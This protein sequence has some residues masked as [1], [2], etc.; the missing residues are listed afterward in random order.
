MKDELFCVGQANTCG[1][2]DPKESVV[3]LYPELASKISI[4]HPEFIPYQQLEY[5]KK[6]PIIYLKNSFVGKEWKRKGLDLAVKILGASKRSTLM[7]W[8]VQRRSST[9]LSITHP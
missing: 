7:F 5:N 9:Y 2:D 8:S 6:A 3:D 1:F 4:A